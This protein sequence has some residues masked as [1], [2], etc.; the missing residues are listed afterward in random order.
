MGRSLSLWFG[1]MVCS[2]AGGALVA[3]ASAWADVATGVLGGALFGAVAGIGV[4]L[5]CD[6]WRALYEWVLLYDTAAA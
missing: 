2:A 1:T 4:V 6:K 5:L 3:S